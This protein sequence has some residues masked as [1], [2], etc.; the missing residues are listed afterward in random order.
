LTNSRSARRQIL[1]WAEQGAVSADRIAAALALAGA[2]PNASQWRRFVSALLLWLGVLLVAT[3]VIFFFAYNWQAMGRFTKFG[4]AEALLAISVAAAWIAGPER[5]AGK[6]SLLLA[7]LV[8]GALLALIGQTYQTGADT[9]ELFAWWAALILPWV[10]VART[11]ALWLL[12]IALLNLAVTFYFQAFRG[13]FPEDS[14][15]WSLFTLNTG[16]L[17]AWEMAARRG[18]NWMQERWAARLLAMA[19][20]TVATVLGTWGIVDSQEAGPLAIPFY[21]AWLAGAYVHYRR[22]SLDLFVLAGGVLSLIVFV[23]TSLSH[24]MLRHADAG[25]FLLIGVVVIAMSAAGAWWL[26]G[27]ASKE[28]VA[29]RPEETEAGE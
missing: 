11:P 4:L 1:E 19:S 6:A 14:I 27:I 21:L 29:E 2:T 26:K 9:F 20:G 28:A 16:A 22:Q 7:S 13:F 25:S 8:T 17:I 24:F 3:G 12:W 10:A 23:A 15:V 18:W 5:A